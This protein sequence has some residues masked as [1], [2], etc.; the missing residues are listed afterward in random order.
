MCDA[1]DEFIGE[2]NEEEIA[3]ANIEKTMKILNWKPKHKIE[4]YIK[5]AVTK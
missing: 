3:F 4:D 1:K 2:R 5:W